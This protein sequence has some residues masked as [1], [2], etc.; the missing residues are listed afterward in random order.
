MLPINKDIV[1]KVKSYNDK[2]LS[3]E[4]IGLLCGIT[5]DSV[6]LILSGKY[7]YLLNEEP[8][9]NDGTTVIPYETLKRLIACEYAVEAILKVSK[10]SEVNDNNLFFPSNSVYGLLRAY[11]PE[12][13]LARIQELQELKDQEEVEV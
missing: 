13:T 12:E 3:P 8:E 1:L 4:E 10:L 6:S 2:N 11:L 5:P 9:I 7:D